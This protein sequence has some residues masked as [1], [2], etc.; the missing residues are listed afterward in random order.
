L[1]RVVPLCID[2]SPAEVTGPLAAFQARELNEAGMKRLVQDLSAAS[3]NPKDLGTVFEAMWP[4]LEAAVTEAI[5]AAPA[6]TEP[7]RSPDDMLKELV[8]R[9]RRIDRELSTE[10]G[11]EPDEAAIFFTKEF[12]KQDS[13]LRRHTHKG[14]VPS[15]PVS[16]LAAVTSRT[17]TSA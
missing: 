8:E 4:Q 7:R 3:E 1:A 17:W 10:A 15:L 6:D 14:R 11:E 5:N 16:I 12:V 2:L 13:L 9:I